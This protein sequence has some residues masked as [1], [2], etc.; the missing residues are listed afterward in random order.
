M[1]RDPLFGV[2][3]KLDPDMEATV[4]PGPAT[5]DEILLEDVV[6]YVVSLVLVTRDGDLNLPPVPDGGI[7]VGGLGDPTTALGRRSTGPG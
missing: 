5:V 2:G 7:G 3:R 6:V 1:T 4:G